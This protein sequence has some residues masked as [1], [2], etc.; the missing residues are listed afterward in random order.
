MLSKTFKKSIEDFDV[1]VVNFALCTSDSGSGVK[2]AAVDFC[3]Q[4]EILRDWCFAHQVC[5]ACENALGTA[6]PMVASKNPAAREVVQTV[7]EVVENIATVKD[8]GRASPSQS[9][10]NIELHEIY[11]TCERCFLPFA[12][13]FS[14]QRD[15]PLKVRTIK[16][17]SEA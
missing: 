14:L 17:H 2:V 6:T 7:I 11:V 10:F 4:H 1:T 15:I 9:D 16:G 13:T 8:Q 3:K 5:K 12:R